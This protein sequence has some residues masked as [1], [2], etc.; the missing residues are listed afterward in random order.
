MRD[1]NPHSYH[2]GYLLILFLLLLA[3]SRSRDPNHSR[4]TDLLDWQAQGL[5]AVFA[6]GRG[7]E[8]LA[9]LGKSLRHHTIHVPYEER[10]KL[11]NEKEV[12]G[13]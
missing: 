7:L 9:R 1:R 6:M 10:Q 8:E 2:R 11:D 5:P 12:E 3:Q 13:S 4:P